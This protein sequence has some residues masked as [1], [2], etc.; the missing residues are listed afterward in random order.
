MVAHIAEVKLW[1]KRVGA[2]AESMDSAYCV[3]EYDPKWIASGIEISPIHLPLKRKKFLFPSLP[4]ATYKGLPACFADALPDDFGNA[5]IDAWLAREGLPSDSFTAVKRL[6]YTGTRGMGAIEYL[7]AIHTSQTIAS[8]E[9]ESLL[10][11]AQDILDSRGQLSQ[12][13]AHDPSDALTTMLQ[14]GTSAGGAR[15]KAVIGINR[16]RTEL[17][18]GQV[19]LPDDFEHY[20]LKF[21]GVSE[22]NTQRETFGD[23]KG[24]G[25]MEYAYYLMAK[26][27]GIHMMPSELLEEG[28]R[29][30]FM[31]KRFDRINNQKR[32]YQSLC[33]MD[34]ADFKQ[35]GN[36]SY[37][38][39]FATMRRLKLK[40]AEAL[41]MF[42]RMTF[43]IVAK[44]HDD[45]SKNI[46][47][48]LN[49]EYRWELAPAFDIAYSY[50]KDSPWVN[51]HQLSLNGKRDYFEKSDLL[52]VAE[53][54]KKEAITIIEQVNDAISQWPQYAQ[55][56]NVDK[57][58]AS[59][60]QAQHCFL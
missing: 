19:T 28:N 15:P 24:Y 32:H 22:H 6:L 31:S 53:T 49:N 2:I 46:G 38:Q 35:P 34:H 36:Y 20:I 37:E 16:E 45:H 59:Q 3:F 5:V 12:S 8:V 39:L 44:N 25:R 55:Q 47:F 21:D 11:V 51:A 10:K 14:V 40:R 42:R 50:K 27:A 57:N 33:A 7:P 1:G 26:A 52:V 43:N 29:A 9:L 13:I 23:P 18:S 17:R 56:A 41:E 60:I 48:L 54:F 30:H 58:F 4:L